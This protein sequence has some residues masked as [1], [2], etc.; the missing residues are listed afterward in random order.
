MEPDQFIDPQLLPQDRL[1]LDHLLDDIAHRQVLLDKPTTSDA[2][3]DA[4]DS[5][6]ESAE[7]QESMFRV[8]TPAMIIKGLS[9]LYDG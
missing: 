9:M 1:V 8:L 6:Y 2:A 5:G 3:S 7:V 4:S